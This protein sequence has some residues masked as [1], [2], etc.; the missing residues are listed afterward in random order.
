M[1][2]II[3]IMHLSSFLVAHLFIS[4]VVS[5]TFT[6]TNSCNY[7][8]WPGVSSAGTGPAFS[9][10]GFSLEKNES[11]ILKAPASWTGRFWGRTY[12]TEDS[13]GN[14]SCITGDC[15]S[16]KLE[17][18]GSRGAPPATLAEFGL[19]ISGGLDFYDVS[20]V[21]GFNLPLLV[22]PSSQSCS[23]TGCIGDVN[24]SCPTELEV[25]T[26]T[27]GKRVGCKGAC[28]AH[29]SSIYCCDGTSSSPDI[30]KPPLY[31]NFFKNLCPQSYSYVFDDFTNTTYTC[32]P[33]DYQITF[34]P[35]KSNTRKIRPNATT[36]KWVPIIA[37]V[38]GGV[39]AIISFVVIVVLRV[40][41]SKSEDTEE[42]EEDDHVQQV[43]GMPVRFS[44]RDLCI[45][46]D[47]FKET[48]GKGGFGSV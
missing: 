25:T 11:K 31:S 18:S 26:G 9:T 41:W 5:T 8:V 24:D 39:L 32:P 30:C 47:D 6:I 28:D 46:A 42:D 36:R 22:V 12:C 17:C 20:L 34:C 2:R 33:T 16:G 27:E 14:F 29:S 4:G 21:Y 23:I 37:G 1:S 48:L 38:V 3:L 45:A 44:Y 13:S 19:G 43:P 35:G 10:T 7:T 15:G 40:R